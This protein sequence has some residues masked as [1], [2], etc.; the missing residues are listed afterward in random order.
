MAAPMGVGERVAEL[1]NLSGAL[2]GTGHPAPSS[3]SG[4]DW[5]APNWRYWR[6][7]SAGRTGNGWC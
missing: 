2:G 7:D 6:N 4:E 5:E 3:S 1:L